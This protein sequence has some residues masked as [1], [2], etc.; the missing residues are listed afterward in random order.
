MSNATPRDPEREED[1]TLRDDD[2]P[3]RAS[4]DEVLDE[5][6]RLAREGRR[7]LESDPKEQKPTSD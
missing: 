7:A 6:A 3:I 5:T 1:G 2:Q 4:D